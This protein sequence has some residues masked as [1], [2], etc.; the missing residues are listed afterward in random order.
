M[1]EGF[2]KKVLGVVKAVAPMVAGVVL[3]GSGSLVQ[4][5]MR[6]V[7]GDG[8]DTDIEAVAE[9]IMADPEKLVELKRIAAD[10]EIR[11]AEIAA[12]REVNLEQTHT[13]RIEAVNVT[14]QAEAAGGHPW[15]GAW[16]PFWGFASAVAFFCIVGG[17]IAM[18]VYAIKKSDAA[19]LGHI[20]ALVMAVST[21]FAIPGAIL[22][23]A[24][25]HRGQM[26]RAAAGDQRQGILTTALSAITGK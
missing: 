12:D 6:Q 22:G 9:K 21:L 25:W 20:P 7:T 10:R 24:S 11:L 17:I 8:P 16:R 13:D 19:L 26:Q 3:P 5:L 14:M 15:S 1:P 18:G 2:F 4:T 23:V